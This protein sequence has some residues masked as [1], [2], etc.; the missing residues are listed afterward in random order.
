MLSTPTQMFSILN[1]MYVYFP[2]ADSTPHT[3]PVSPT[4][5][6][7]SPAHTDHTSPFLLEVP[8]RR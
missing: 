8:R 2:H 3:R 1:F 7:P 4:V 6:S 5:Q